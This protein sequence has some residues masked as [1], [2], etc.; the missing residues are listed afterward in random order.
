MRR[1]AYGAALTLAMPAAA[2]AQQATP[3]ATAAAAPIEPARLAAARQVIDLIMPPA[4]RAAM[5]R[6]ML[7]PMLTN[8]R[9]GMM[10]A[11]VFADAIGRDQRARA[12]FDTFMTRQNEKTMAMLEADLP[13]MVE[14][15]SRAYA[16]RF[17][18]AQLG[19]LRTFFETPTGQV[20]MREASTLMSDP[21]VA[22]WQ[23]QMMAR[24][25]ERVQ[26]D[27]AAF[28]KDMAKIQQDKK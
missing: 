10:Q 14:A 13:S 22:A 26:Q 18:V 23:R 12:T 5:I 24:S 3:P 6:S 19:D 27:V 17:T 9:Q 11:P 7:D 1:I 15:M 16:R 25:M 28:A 21:D 2:L 20:Y 4:T 8:I